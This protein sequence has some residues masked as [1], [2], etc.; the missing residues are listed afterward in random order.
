[1]TTNYETVYITDPNIS[2]AKLG[3]LNTKLSEIVKRFQG[4]VNGIEDWGSRRLGYDIKKQNT[5]HYVLF[6][7]TAESGAIAEIEH[8][9]KLRDDILKQMTIR[10]EEKEGKKDE[11]R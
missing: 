10:L 1:M 9:L 6:H 3:E 2:E 4:K 11:R 7:F 5:G 8:T